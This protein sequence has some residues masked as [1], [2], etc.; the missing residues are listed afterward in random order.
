MVYLDPKNDVSFKKV[1]GRHPRVL[2][3]FLNALLPIPQDQPIVHIEYLDTELLP[4]IPM[5]KTTVVDIRCRDNKGRQFLV[6]MQLVYTES[7]ESRVL[8]NACKA[9]SHQINRGD[10]YEVLMPVYSLNLVNQFFSRQTSECYHY[11]QLTHQ[12]MPNQFIKGLHIV[13][14]EIPNFIPANFSERKLTALWLRFL[15]EIENRTTMI[16]ADLLEVPEIAEAVEALKEN[17]YTK[18][19]LEQY[20]KYWDTLRIQKAYVSDAFKEGKNEGKLEGKLEGRL[21]GRIE[22]ASRMKNKGFS[23]LEIC[24]VTGLTLNDIENLP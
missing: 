23:P 9:F 8:F 2:I 22:V 13:L 3:S 20:D 19:E 18:E 17:S 24:E 4:D 6:E 1:F 21:E 15:K 12:T 5:F 7:F 14:V 10:P 11:F 16:P